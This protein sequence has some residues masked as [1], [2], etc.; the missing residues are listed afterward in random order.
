MFMSQSLEE[1]ELEKDVN[2]FKNYKM[3][4]GFGG[5][6]FLL[7]NISLGNES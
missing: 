3:V 1:K 6:R 2:K 7:Q 4:I 5:G